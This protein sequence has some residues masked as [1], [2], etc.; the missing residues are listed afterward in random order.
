MGGLAGVVD[1]FGE[2]GVGLCEAVEFFGDFGVGG[3]I[4]GVLFTFDEGMEEGVYPFPSEVSW[5]VLEGEGVTDVGDI[6]GVE[7]GR[8]G[9]CVGVGVGKHGAQ[10]QGDI[11]SGHV[12]IFLLEGVIPYFDGFGGDIEVG[13]EFGSFWGGVDFVDGVGGD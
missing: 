9:A 5:E 13:E 6:A 12:A 1:D 11:V 10:E 3:G 8:C 4:H 2:F 7:G